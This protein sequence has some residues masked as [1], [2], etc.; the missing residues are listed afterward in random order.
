MDFTLLISFLGA[1]IVLTLMP[2]P[3]NLFVLAQSISQ[4]KRAGI[5][6]TLGL[7]TG[8]LCHTIAAALGISAIIYQ[9]S[10]AFAIVKYAGAIYL[11]YLAW[12]AF[13]EE[14]QTY[15]M[16]QQPTL[17]FRKLYK[18]GI[19]MN[20]L[21][22]K[23]SLF[24]LALFPQFIDENSGALL[25]PVQMV[26]LGCVFLLQALVIFSLVSIFAEKVGEWLH[27]SPHIGKRMNIIKGVL[28]GLIGLKLALG[29]KG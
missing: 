4:N 9:S 5:A 24:F 22:P 17:S 11:L 14:G 18:R 6:T 12:E 21:N 2:G 3:D 23:V 26:I 1:A 29:Q 28:F 16:D 13:R 25:V 7:C 15:T 8:I 10:F 19:F 20:V 27:K